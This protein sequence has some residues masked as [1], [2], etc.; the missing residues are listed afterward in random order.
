MLGRIS[1]IRDRLKFS[2]LFKSH[3]KIG[4][5]FH[6]TTPLE[7]K[8]LMGSLEHQKV[9]SYLVFFVPTFIM[10]VTEYLCSGSVFFFTQ[11]SPF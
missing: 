5:A 2:W 11:I 3:T 8:D 1:I 4:R 7:K 6:V 10:K 9:T